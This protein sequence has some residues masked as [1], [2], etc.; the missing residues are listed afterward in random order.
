MR[1]VA[2]KEN[3]TERNKLEKPHGLRSRNKIKAEECHSQKEE[4][5]LRLDIVGRVLEDYI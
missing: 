4:G 3:Y 2:A 1:A 5:I